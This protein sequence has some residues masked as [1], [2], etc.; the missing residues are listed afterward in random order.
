MRLMTV[1]WERLR[2][3]GI[4]GRPL[5]KRAED[6]VRRLVASQAQ[7][8]AGAKWALGL[9]SDGLDDA[10][11]E[12]AFDRG[13]LLRTH[14]M[15]PTWHFVAPEDLRWL[16]ALTSSRVEAMNGP[17]YRELGLDAATLRK[18]TACIARALEGGREL[19]R[20]ELREVLAR[21]RIAADGQR[22]AYLL[23][24]AELAAVVCSGARRGKQFTHALLDE[25]APAARSRSRQD[26]LVE[27]ARRYFVSRGPATVHDFAKWSGLTV[28]DACAGVEG[29]ASKLRR[30]AIDG[31]T[32]W[33]GDERVPSHR[34]P[35]VAHLLSI[36]D[37]Y[38]S[39][40]RDRTTL[41][42]PADAKRLVGKGNALAYVVILDGQIAGTWRRAIGKGVVRVQV[43][44]FQRWSR[45]QRDAVETAA[46]RFAD[47]L[48]VGLELKLGSP[49]VP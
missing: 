20:D 28:G 19:T 32:Y 4:E 25:R 38:I 3:Q 31:A 7:D 39:S 45:P 21:S 24:H 40:Y 8:F 46:E 49:A 47:F 13:A 44:P 43:A 10:A 42:D 41:C 33:S 34:G 6:V 11:I 9:R 14:V 5:Q 18:A 29:V 22:M 17:R 48:R 30:E 23:M 26:A 35:P 16:Q 2:N 1:A 36:Y 12:A 27:L 15:R 37:E